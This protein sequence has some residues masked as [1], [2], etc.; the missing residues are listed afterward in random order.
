[1][2]EALQALKAKLNEENY[3]AD[4]A[5]AAT[6]YIAMKLNRPLLIEGAA[7]VG[8]TE[9][10]KAAARAFGREL[11]RLQCYEGLDESK[12]LYEW[13]Y[14][15]QLLAIQMGQGREGRMEDL[16]GEAYLLERPLLKSIR[17]EKPVV[18]LIDEIDKADA[19]FEAF[20]LEL[21]SEMQVTIPEYGT[22]KAVS[23]PFIV[24]TSN[25]TRPLS[26]ALRRRCAYLYLEYPDVRREI[27]ILRARLP[28]L[29]EALAA[30]VAR[31]AAYLRQSEK[32][33][34]KPS[35]AESLDWAEALMALGAQELDED[36]AA[37]TLGFALKNNDD[38]REIMADDEFIRA[39]L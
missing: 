9:V 27:E 31:A 11:V 33:T 38:I 22:V 21:L 15:K 26:E 16:F 4:D 32:V 13:N 1:M 28:G 24:L 18:L 2:Q 36:A 10:A 19:E 34:K 3:I 12:A 35:V 6:L 23:L 30:Q 14:Q 8:K 5:L 25:H 29:D 20:L 17:A 37:Q 7:G 39:I